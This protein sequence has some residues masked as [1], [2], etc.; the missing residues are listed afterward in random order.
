MIPCISSWKA[1]IIFRS[2][3]GHAIL[4]STVKSPLQ[5]T[6]SK[7]LVRSIRRCIMA[8]FALGNF[9]CSCLSEKIMTIL[10]LPALNLHCAS[11]IC[12][13]QVTATCSELHGQGPSQQDWGG[14][15][16]GS[17]CSHYDLLCSWRVSWCWHYECSGALVII[18]IIINNN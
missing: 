10:D 1:L 15:F 8:A 9:S 18:I 3:E 11:G 14:I 12:V 16:H 17:C 4:C 5:L 7:A 13:L 6:K 2:L